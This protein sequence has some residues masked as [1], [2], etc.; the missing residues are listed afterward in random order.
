MRVLI[1]LCKLVVSVVPGFISLTFRKRKNRFLFNKCLLPGSCESLDFFPK[2]VQ[3][4]FA[5]RIRFF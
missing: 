4:G 2:S 5:F 1:C 3:I